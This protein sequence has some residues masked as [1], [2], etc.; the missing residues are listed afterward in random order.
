MAPKLTPVQKRAITM[1][2]NSGIA[3]SMNVIVAPSA[4]AERTFATKADRAAGK[5]FTCPNCDRN[6]LRVAPVAGR[7]FHDKDT[8]GNDEVCDLR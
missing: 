7:S 6:D 8:K 2:R 5:G 3:V 1:L 4:S